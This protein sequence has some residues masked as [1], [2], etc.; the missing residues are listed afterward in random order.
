MVRYALHT[1][2]RFTINYFSRNVDNVLVG[3]RFGAH[4]LGFYKKAYDLFALSASQ[5]TAPLTNIAVAALSRSDPR[6]T[7]FR[8]HLLAA[9]SITA[10]A[11]MGLSAVFL[12]V[13]KNLILLLL[14]PGWEP[15]GKIFVVFS[16]GIGAMFIYYAISWIH[17]SI[18]RPDRWLR[19]GLIEVSVTC[20]LF[21]V[22]LSWGSVGIAG[23]WSASFWILIVPG[24][25]YA[26]RP[27]RLGIGPVVTAVWRYIAASSLALCIC[28]SIVRALPVLIAPGISA[29]LETSALFGIIYLASVV[30][31]HGSYR[32]VLQFIALLKEMLSANT[33]VRHV[34]TL[35]VAA[36]GGRGSLIPSTGPR[37]PLVSILIP[38][39]NAQEWIGDTLRS[40][41]AQTWEPKEVIVVDDGST[42]RTAEIARQ[43]ESDHV[44]VVTQKN[45]GASVA[46]NH[47]FSLSRGDYIQWL[48]ADDLLA[49]DK[50]ARQMAVLNDSLDKRI[51]LS[52]SWGRFMH[53]WHRADFKPTALW[54][55][56]SPRTWL[57][58]KMK[59]NLY[60]QT[61]TWLVSRELTE[62]AGPWDS[63][64][65]GDD[66]GEYFCRVLLGSKLVRFVPE[67]KV[68]YRTPIFSSLSYLGGSKP[69]FEA[70]WISMESHIRYLRFLQD[71]Q[72]ARSACLKY[73]QASFLYFYPEHSVVVHQMEELARELG[74]SLARPRLPWKYAWIKL[75][76]GWRCAKRATVLL[77]K[78][79]SSVKGQIEKAVFRIERSSVGAGEVAVECY[80]DPD[81]RFGERLSE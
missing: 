35:T 30:L 68:Y 4:D 32:P 53:R 1:Y 33:T 28:L 76:F 40:A 59:H 78:L 64:L 67:A 29:I 60:M 74:G 15:A 7:E 37:S 8:Q 51:L 2:A 73:L 16:P 18:G 44:R 77:P 6:S 72:D 31:L 22:M 21:V 20:V 55:D 52:S 24:F 9:L 71:D 57:L 10:F 27:I 58:L 81:G 63:R 39:Y 69:K 65:L 43:F 3:W 80:E 61:A 14:G 23:A 54:S 38:A 47:A 50:I 56:L 41:L 11:G 19:W 42:D 25:W 70:H 75:V 17:L 45:Q 26:G 13:G 66:D 79:K 5:I 36:T 12:L 62:A 49:P 34:P 46:R 48:D